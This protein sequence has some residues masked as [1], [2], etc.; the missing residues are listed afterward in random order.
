VAWGQESFQVSQRRACGAFGVARSSVCYRSIRPTQEPLRAR[1]REIA[2]IRVSYGYRRVHVLLRREGWRVNA[3]RVRRLYRDEGLSLRSKKPKRRR[4]A[5]PRVERP[6]G[7]TP[8][9]RWSMD[10]MSDALADGRK[11]RVLTVL[12]TCTRECLA[13][14]VA[15]TF[16]GQRV[17]DVLTRVGIYRGLSSTITVDNGTEFTSR[18]LD[19][20][21]YRNRVKL[22]YTRPG[23]P[24]DNGFIESFNAR[25]RSECLSQH[26]F[27][28]VEDAR[29]VL[30]LWRD[31]YNHQRPHSSLGQ[32]TPAEAA[33]EARSRGTHGS[34][35]IEIV[36]PRTSY[37]VGLQ[38]TEAVITEDRE[39]LALRRA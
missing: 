19:Y 33:A 20:W 15:S 23:K 39:E 29:A 17:A 35:T 4:S 30:N 27:S 37:E 32:R 7:R 10:F 2:S 12:D 11:L 8:N 38:Q 26:Y 1:I 34:G 5:S 16:G 14:E 21:A 28:S 25:V 9:E 13:L 18:A 3:K 36:D 24:T 6:A 22:D 31:E